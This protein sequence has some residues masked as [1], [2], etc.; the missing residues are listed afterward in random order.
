MP[1][2]ADRNLLFG[3][4]A[5]QMD[6]LTREQLLD[7]FQLWMLQKDTPVAAV[8]LRRGALQA[9][10]VEVVEALL[11]RRL[12]RHGGDVQHS[13]A[14]LRVETPVEEALRGLGD[15]EVAR[16]IGHCVRSGAAP[17]E[18]TATVASGHG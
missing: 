17:K 5:L 6:L 13:L 7:G 14:A 1:P 8:L 11:Q 10:D 3:L 9:P 16:S 4:L 12:A 18:G 15:A 2:S